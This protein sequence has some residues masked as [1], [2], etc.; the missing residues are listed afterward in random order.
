MDTKRAPLALM[1][2]LCL[3]LSGCTTSQVV[4]NLQVALDAIT[5]ALPILGSVVAVPAPLIALVENYAT[6]ANTALGEA[7]TILAG[8]G[9]DA[10]K[11]ALIAAA[12]AKL[13]VPDVPAQF[14][15]IANLVSTIAGDI[16]QFL[17]SLPGKLAVARGVTPHTTV[18]SAADLRK[19]GHAHGTANENAVKLAALRTK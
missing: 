8:A 19:L 18:F 14:A 4:N 12:F 2:A 16:A 10:E 5:V 7:S 1:L 9:T 17:G 11:A 15:A 6:Q 3:I 13:G